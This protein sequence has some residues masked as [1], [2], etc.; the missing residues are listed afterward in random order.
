MPSQAV[1]QTPIDNLA[2][3]GMTAAVAVGVAR[4]PGLWQRTVYGTATTAAKTK[5]L[6]TSNKHTL[7]CEERCKVPSQAF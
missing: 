4:L 7:E 6:R 5:S 3:F 1:P 2:E